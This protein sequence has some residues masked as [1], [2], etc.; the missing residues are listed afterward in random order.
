MESELDYVSEK[1]NE[2]TGIQPK[3]FRPPFGDYNNT[4]L[5][6][7]EEKN[8]I[9]VQWTVDSLELERFERCRNPF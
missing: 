8:M 1:V 5:E 2:L 3:F 4:L 6:V 9:G 7:V